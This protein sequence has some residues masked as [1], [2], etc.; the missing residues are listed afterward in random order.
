MNSNKVSNPKVEVPNTSAMNDRDYMNAILEYEK[1]MA[2]NLSIALSE[3][4]NEY[5]FNEIMP[6]FN[7]V[8]KAGRDLYYMMFAKGW[9]SL[10]QAEE[11]KIKQKQNELQNKMS[12]LIK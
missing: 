8:K 4:S 5:L 7:S 1:N 12:E 2:N 3:A 10:E 9:Y 6:M 11:Q